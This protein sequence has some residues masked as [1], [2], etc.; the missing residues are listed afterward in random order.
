MGRISTNVGLASGFPIQETVDKLVTL[1]AGPRNQLQAK[2]KKLQDEQVAFTSL[3]AMLIALQSTT[4]RLSSATLYESRTASSSLPDALGVTVSGQPSVGNYQFTP[5][6]R[7]QAQQF[8]SD[9][10]ASS[11]SALGAGSLTLRHGG[12]VD[13]PASLDL[14]GGGAGFS[15]GKIRITDRS[16]ASAIV[17]LTQARSVNDVQE[18][19]RTT[20]G[21]NVRAEAVGDK[22]RLIDQTG[23][24]SANLQVQEVGGGTSAASLG[25]AGINVASAQ[26]DGLD[27][28]R[29]FSA[30]GLDSLNDGRGVRFDTATAD[31]RI[32]T[33]DGGTPIDIDF[34]RLASSVPGGTQVTATNEKSLGDV[35]AAINAA[36]PSRLRASLAADGERIVLE[37]ISTDQGGTFSA[38]SLNSSHALADLGLDGAA[39]GGVITGR[40]LLSGLKTTLLSSLDGGKG[41][42]SL[43]LLNLQSRS[44]ASTT[45]NLAQAETLDDVV[46][47]INAAGVAISA[48]VNDARNGILINDTS[49]ATSGNL[50][51]SNGDGTTRTADRLG[52]AI[53]AAQNSKNSADLHRQV[54]NENTRLASLNGAAGVALGTFRILDS[55]GNGRTVDIT[56]KVKTVGDVITAINRLGLDLVARINDTGDGIAIVDSAGGEGKLTVQEGNSTTARDLHLLGTPTET[57]VDGVHT[58]LLDASTNFKIT[59]GATESLD[60]LAQRINDLHAGIT[61]GVLNDGSSIK[62]FRLTLFNQNSGAQ[63]QLLLDTSLSPIGFHETVAAQDALLLVGGTGDSG[64]GILASSPT[65]SF[66]SLIPGLTLEVKQSSATPATVTVGNQT[67][68]LVDAVQSIVDAYNR[69]HDRIKSLTAF[70]EV[71][72]TSALLQGDGSVL[73]V[74][75]DLTRLLT[76]R[77]SSSGSARSLESLGIGI[78]KE[79]SL[80]LDASKLQT[81]LEQDPVAVR[82]LLSHADTGVSDRFKKVI[83]S[84]AGIGNSL[85]VGKAASLSQTISLNTARIEFLN[86]RLDAVRTKLLTSFTASESA[87]SKLQTNLQVVNRISSIGPLSVST[88]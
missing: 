19:I 54:V 6:R 52:I 63:G 81:R 85:L 82:D 66:A 36:A 8:Q 30:L 23:Q 12:F 44:G 50:V 18:A 5:L 13:G 21:I 42:A 67:K 70:D 46:R 32:T 24:S 77:F 34:Q 73:R 43:G 16:G 76:A 49:G 65:N 47:A 4:N 27:V 29:L 51:I 11:T 10:V 62:P 40:R 60:D 56:T 7:A 72:K 20:S 78:D 71:K 58:F 15:R 75:S 45:V 39:V 35:L 59:L 57:T 55:K 37:D 68:P 26:A 86:G 22:F 38:T 84:L 69:L 83:D 28:V 88:R 64:A 87:I 48:R 79:G 53:N 14:L 41:L 31:L 2:N 25:L 61:A 33:R 1:H 9:T 3:T 80:T 74:E 17:D